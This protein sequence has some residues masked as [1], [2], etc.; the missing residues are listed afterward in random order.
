MNEKLLEDMIKDI[1][2]N[3]GNDEKRPTDNLGEKLTTKDYPIQEKHPELIKTPTNKTLDDITID[4]VVS[5]DITSKDIRVAPET[6]E[7]Q[8]QVAESAGRKPLA[9]NLRRAAEL[10]AV[11]D[12]RI[13]EVYNA[14]RPNR[15]TKEELL[16]IADELE[17]QYQAKINADFI[18]EAADVYAERDILRVD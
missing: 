11:P 3:M 16:E 14:L 6:L 12:N 13:I 15:S 4:K 7:L 5:G 1:I 18:R 2:S 8:A 17:K 10:T 9:K